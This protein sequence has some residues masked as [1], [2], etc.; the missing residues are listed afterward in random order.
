MWMELE[1]YGVCRGNPQQLS[2]SI[3]Y[4]LPRER[5][6]KY[7]RITVLRSDGSGQIVVVVTAASR[8]YVTVAAQRP[9]VPSP[10]RHLPQRYHS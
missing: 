8:R 6:I 1:G 5:T 4:R 2:D 10:A 7:K 3:M 9:R